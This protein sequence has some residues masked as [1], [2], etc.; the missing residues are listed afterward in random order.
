MHLLPLSHNALVFSGPNVLQCP[1]EVALRAFETGIG[2]ILTGLEVGVD[3]LNQS[4]KV[5]GGDGFVLLVE[6]INVAVQ[7]FDKEFYG[8]G[9]VHAGIGNTEGTLKALENPFSI[10]LFAAF[11]EAA[12]ERAHENRKGHRV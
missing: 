9:R 6:I 8:N 3:E 1:F 2:L 12:R 11:G 4:V 7:D 10:A 5:L